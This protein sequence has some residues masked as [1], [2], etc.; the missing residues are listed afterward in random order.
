MPG[1]RTLLRIPSILLALSSGVDVPTTNT[2]RAYSA[3][4]PEDLPAQ[5]AATHHCATLW[6]RQLFSI[7]EIIFFLT[8][9][10]HR[11]NT[12]KTGMFLTENWPL[13]RSLD[14]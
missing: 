12:S 5:S 2:T 6:L 1:P 8:N 3:A 4:R 11:R 9:N 7:A 10:I 13:R 14:R